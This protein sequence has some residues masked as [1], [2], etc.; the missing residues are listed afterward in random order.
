MSLQNVHSLLITDIGSVHTRLML[1]DLVEGQFRLIGSSRAPTTAEPPLANAGLGLEHAVQS[2]T[3]TIGR[4]LL[5]PDTQQLFSMPEMSGEGVDEFLATGSAGRPMRVC[6]VG[7]TPE[8]SLASARRVLAGSYNTITDVISADDI[9][10]EA[11]MINAV[12][13]GEPD[14]VLIVGG[15]DDGA[16][17]ILLDLVDRVRTALTL[18]RRGT[19]PTVLYAGNKA[20]KRQIHNRL[21]ALTKVVYARNVRPSLHE[22]RIFPVQTELALV[23]DD[24][25]GKSPGDFAA[26]GRQSRV[27]VVPTIQGYINSVRYLSQIA[28]DGTGPLIVDVGSANSVILAGVRRAPHFNVH[29]DLG[30]GHNIVHAVEAVGPRNVLRW[31]PF[32]LSEDALWDYACN[33]ALRP[34]T[35]PATPEELQIEQAVAREIVRRLADES[36]PAW[37]S[38]QTFSPIIA[39]GATLTEAQHPG[40]SALLLLDA[41]QP[42]GMVELRLDPHNLI[43]GLGVAAYLNPL[44]TVQ[45]LETGGLINLGTAFCPDGHVRGGRDALSIQLRLD[46]G[47]VINRTV[48]GGEIWMA[49]ILPGVTARLT[50][51]LRSGLTIDGKRRLK[52]RVTAGAAGIIF[53]A[54]GRPLTLARP[55]DRAAQLLRWQ[56]AMS[57]QDQAPARPA[58]DMQPGLDDLYPAEQEDEYALPS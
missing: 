39:A 47:K 51:R 26:V 5:D 6:L 25:L 20:L 45:A 19:I 46:D 56:A 50:L 17:E 34:G 53:D 31:L 14:L 36:R 21:G 18:I 37:G 54:R 13:R 38:G 7:L 49:P 1:I 55:K 48:R 11:E 4:R 43:S 15:T 32:E 40:I 22:E 35:V 12:L 8:L 23:Y 42:R 27:G 2:M 57:G 30:V 41:L 16:D 10:S 29:T 33:K 58:A 9:R 28:P 24:Y 52:L 44:I 3:E